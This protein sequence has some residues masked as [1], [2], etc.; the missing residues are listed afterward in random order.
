M[1]TRPDP[2]VTKGKVSILL[3]AILLIVGLV[4]GLG[5]GYLIAPAPQASQERVLDL[6]GSAVELTVHAGHLN[7]KFSFLISGSHMD[8]LEGE[9]LSPIEGLLNPTVRVKTGANVTVNFRNVDWDMPHSMGFVAQGPPYGADPP[10]DMAFPGAETP[11]VH[12]GTNSDV[13]EVFAFTAT[14]AGTYWY[15]CHVPGH[16]AAA[17]YGKFVVS[18]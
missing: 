2:A 18:P 5:V 1:A 11:M 3:A 4:V 15:V 7:G 16:A 13:N 8:H 17:M 14:P 6:S 12:V 9:F 10:E